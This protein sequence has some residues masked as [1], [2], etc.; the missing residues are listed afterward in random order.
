LKDL[1][2]PVRGPGI[3]HAGWCAW[4]GN[5]SHIRRIIIP[6]T[7]NPHLGDSEAHLAGRCCTGMG[8]TPQWILQMYLSICL[9]RSPDGTIDRGHKARVEQR[10]C[11]PGTCARAPFR[12]RHGM[13]V[14]TALAVQQHHHVHTAIARCPTTSSCQG[15]VAP[16]TYLVPSKSVKQHDR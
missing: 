14:Q 12:R 3:A 16:V 7:L 2:I 13:H 9:T 11:T 8:R 10:R 4:G 1:I 6:R 15:S 5:R